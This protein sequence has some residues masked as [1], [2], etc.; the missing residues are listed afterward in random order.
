VLLTLFKK[1]R[2][3]LQKNSAGEKRIRL[4]NLP[5]FT[6]FIEMKP[7]FKVS[8]VVKIF[9]N[10]SFLTSLEEKSKRNKIFLKFGSFWDIFG[11]IGQPFA[12]DF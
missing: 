7:V 11:K 6:H 10:S 3:G 8:I 2:L 4:V 5:F 1:R 12:A 9:N